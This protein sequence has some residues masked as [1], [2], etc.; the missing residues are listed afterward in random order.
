MPGTIKECTPTPI[1]FDAT[2]VTDQEEH[3]RKLKELDH[4]LE[5]LD[6]RSRQL[7]LIIYNLP[8]EREDPLTDVWEMIDEKHRR[9]VCVSEVPQR[10]G[11]RSSDNT[12]SRPVR[13]KFGTLHGKHLF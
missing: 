2:H 8:E 1:G 13:V 10:M 5:E 6:R 11:R 9:E 3:D 12:R 4:R 7:N